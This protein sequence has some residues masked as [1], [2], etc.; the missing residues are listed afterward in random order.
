MNFKVIKGKIFPAFLFVMLITI[1]A[2][3]A[4]LF[5]HI[6]NLDDSRMHTISLWNEK[7][8]ENK[9]ISDLYIS[10]CL[11]SKMNNSLGHT[12][13]AN[14]KSDLVGIY[15]CGNNM[16]ANKLMV[17]IERSDRSLKTLVFPLSIVNYL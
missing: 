10:K 1:V 17:E 14:H 5:Q 15:D 2:F 12:E 9:K 7:S 16:G 8:P 11:T 13:K 3:F 6:A 4:Q